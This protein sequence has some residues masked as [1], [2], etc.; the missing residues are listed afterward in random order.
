MKRVIIL[1]MALMIAVFSCDAGNRTKNENRKKW[2]EK[3]S[4]IEVVNETAV[5][6]RDVVKIEIKTKDAT[7]VTYVYDLVKSKPVKAAKG[8][9]VI[10][11]KN[12]DYLVLS[13]KKITKTVYD[14]IIE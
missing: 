1:L 12:G 3:D 14:V 11:V 5:I 9:F 13:N 8:S 10:E 2:Y 6:F 4:R 7:Q